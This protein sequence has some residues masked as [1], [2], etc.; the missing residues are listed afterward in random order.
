MHEGQCGWERPPQ[1]KEN[2]RCPQMDLDMRRDRGDL[3]RRG[4]ALWPW[5]GHLNSPGRGVRTKD[6]E[7]VGTH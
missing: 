7:V 2:I 1:G 6:G 4:L 3:G 5:G